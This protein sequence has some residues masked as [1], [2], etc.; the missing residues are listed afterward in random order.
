MKVGIPINTWCNATLYSLGA[1]GTRLS[2]GV[3]I[4]YL[5]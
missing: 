2:L 1:V 5:L 3:P 4:G